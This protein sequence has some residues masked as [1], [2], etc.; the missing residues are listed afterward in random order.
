MSLKDPKNPSSLRLIHAGPTCGKTTA[1]EEIIKPAGSV[2][3][4]T[5]NLI[6]EFAPEW[7][8]LKVYRLSTEKRNPVE[9]AYYL[10]IARSSALL[11]SKWLDAT[12]NGVIF[13]NWWAVEF[14]KHIDPRYLKGGKLPVG[15]FRA[16]PQDIV[17][18]SLKRGGTPIPLSVA[19]FWV[20]SMRK[21]ALDAFDR[22]IWL[23]KDQFLG[24]FIKL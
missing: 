7:N 17:D 10:A 22:F 24:N 2:V 4:D 20:R 16:N 15:F 19:E 9:Q 8:K 23:E 6:E 13:T 12:T 14:I 11:A 1:I 21:H 5:D 18:Y 3:L